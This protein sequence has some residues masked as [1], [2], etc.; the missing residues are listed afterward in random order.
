MLVLTFSTCHVVANTFEGGAR[1]S[2]DETGALTQSSGSPLGQAVVGMTSQ[3]LLMD[4]VLLGPSLEL[5]IGNERAPWGVQAG[6]RIS[7]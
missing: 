2:V 5:R 4:N 3:R 6:I 1:F 7:I